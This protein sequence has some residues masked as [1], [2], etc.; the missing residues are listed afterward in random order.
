MVLYCYVERIWRILIASNFCI[1]YTNINKYYPCEPVNIHTQLSLNT[2]QETNW[3]TT[4]KSGKDK[5]PFFCG[6]G[7]QLIHIYACWKDTTSAVPSTINFS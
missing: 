5:S 3:E 1:T 6:N 4:T 2:M 7:E